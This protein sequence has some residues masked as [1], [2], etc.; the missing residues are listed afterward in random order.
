MDESYGAER[1]HS[2]LDRWPRPRVSYRLLPLEVDVLRGAE[3]ARERHAVEEL[4]ELALVHG[5]AVEQSQQQAERA[6]YQDQADPD[7]EDLAPPIVVA[8]R[9]EGHEG[10]GG[11]EA[12]DEAEEVGVV[13]DPRQ[14]AE[15]QQAHEDE[16][17]L[18]EGAVGVL[19]H[20]PA[21]QHLDHLGGQ[22]GEV[23][24]GWAD[25]SME[26]ARVG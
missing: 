13:V 10:V 9:D 4:A 26:D 16:D 5:H 24:A 6:D 17:E 14:D 7:D 12:E 18:G 21:V 20:R 8:E 23:G 2:A 15:E 3:V 11:E 1:L 25:L 22:Q 19:E